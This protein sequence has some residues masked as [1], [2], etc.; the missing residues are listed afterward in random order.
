MTDTFFALRRIFQLLVTLIFMFPFIGH[1]LSASFPS[2][3]F[4]YFLVNI[5]I[6][7]LGIV[8]YIWVA[9]KY[10]NRQRDKPDNVY[11]YAEEYYAKAH[12]EPNYDV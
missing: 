4:V 3:G 8:V 6:A 1:N 2:C 10:Q 5:V 7:L 11:H 12:D 9:I